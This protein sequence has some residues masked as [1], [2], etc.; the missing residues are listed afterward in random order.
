MKKF[1]WLQGKPR[2]PKLDINQ[3]LTQKIKEKKKKTA[4]QKAKAKE[5]AILKNSNKKTCK[6]KKRHPTELGAIQHLQIQQ[7]S[8]KYDGQKLKVYHCLNCDGWHVGHKLQRAK[9]EQN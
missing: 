2:Q 3:I 4:E 6:R 7:A 5:N 9:N 1:A 8:R